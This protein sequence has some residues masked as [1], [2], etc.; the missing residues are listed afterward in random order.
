[1]Q[2]LSKFASTTKQATLAA[3]LCLGLAAH[4]G[5]APVNT[6]A[7]VAFP[8]A[9]LADPANFTGA[10]TV[11]WS[12][13]LAGSQT[14][15]YLGL[16]NTD[17]N[18][19]TTVGIWNSAGTLLTSGVFDTNLTNVNLD[20][21]GNSG[22]LWLPISQVTLGAGTYTIGAYSSADHFGVYGVANPTTITGLTIVKS[23]LLSFNSA[24]DKPTSDFSG[25]YAQGFFGPNFAA[26][27]PIPVPAAFWLMGSGLMGLF[28]ISKRKRTA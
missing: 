7:A 17:F 25:V 1:M 14:V 10:G 8:T 28:G 26:A 3:V 22:F 5:A 27:A 2:M 21:L 4:A 15:S 9:G 16:Y 18:A 23:S 13:S 11:G 12:F 6:T 20:D 24:L 19:N